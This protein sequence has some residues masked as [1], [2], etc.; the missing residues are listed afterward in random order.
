MAQYIPA[1]GNTDL[2]HGPFVIKSWLSI[3][4]NPKHFR[5]DEPLFA[6]IS[7]GR[8]SGLLAILL[9]FFNKGNADIHFDFENTG[10]EH[11]NTLTFLQQLGHGLSRPITWLE[12]VSPPNVGDA[13]KESRYKYVDFE[14]ASRNG[15]PMVDLLQSLADY[16]R[17]IK[18]E[19]PVAPN[20]VQ[21]ICTAYLKYKTARKHHDLLVPPPDGYGRA[22][23]IRADEIERIRKLKARDD[24]A[25]I[26]HC[27]PLADCGLTKQD[28]NRFW[29]EQEFT[30]DV[31]ENLGNCRLCMLKD[32]SDIAHNLYYEKQTVDIVWLDLQ[33]KFG[34]FLNGGWTFKILEETAPSRF[35]II[36]PALI[37]EEEPV[38]DGSISDRHFKLITNQEKRV[39]K[40]GLIRTPCACESAE[41][42]E[43]D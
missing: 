7:G 13:P 25:R 19:G 22:I 29:S 17:I 10:F 35:N 33:K 37:K 9:D 42:L 27:A 14:T 28:I 15:E 24:T 5:F 36:R 3:R 1:R 2:R 34:E 26:F 30:L 11:N 43:M 20:P 8:T 12:Y 31:P 38:N 16:R 6:G 4:L 18:G 41:L 40:N 23:G 32:Y 21:R 39:L